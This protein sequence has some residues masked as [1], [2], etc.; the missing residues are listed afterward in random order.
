MMRILCW[1]FLKSVAKS[2][3][4][5]EPNG[6]ALITENVLSCVTVDDSLR[7]A[8]IKVSKPP[9]FFSPV[10]LKNGCP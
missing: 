4:L 5:K 1:P 7:S 3:Y 8:H 9:G 10:V 2:R 6:N